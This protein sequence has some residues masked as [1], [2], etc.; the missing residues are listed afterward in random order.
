[1]IKSAI[2]IV[3]LVFVATWLLTIGICLLHVAENW[4]SLLTS[5]AF[6]FLA[7]LI[8]IMAARERGQ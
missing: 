1:V 5:Q 8:T 7:L 3:V 6:I 4:P 2:S